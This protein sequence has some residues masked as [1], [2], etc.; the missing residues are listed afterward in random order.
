MF[1]QVDRGCPSCSLVVDHLTGALVHLSQRDVA[2]AVVSRAAVAQIEAFK[3]RM[4]WDFNWVSSNAND[5]NWDF[6]VSFS[7]EDMQKGVVYYNYKPQKFPAEWPSDEAPGFSVFYKDAENTVYH[8][9]SSFGRGGETAIGTYNF[10]DLVPKGRNEDGL[11]FPMAW[12]R[13]HDRYDS[14]SCAPTE[15]NHCK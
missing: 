7:P 10:L 4:G 3:K 5:F 11:S 6:N 9:Y 12:V 13:H 15:S 8:T 14:R 1:G 2:F